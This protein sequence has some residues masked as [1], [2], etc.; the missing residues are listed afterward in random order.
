M[1]TDPTIVQPRLQESFSLVFGGRMS[2]TAGV[3]SCAAAWR[4]AALIGRLRA[5]QPFSLPDGFSAQRF[6]ADFGPFSAPAQ[7]PP[8]PAPGQQP[9]TLLTLTAKLYEWV[10]AL[11]SEL[12]RGRKLALHTLSPLLAEFRSSVLEIPGQYGGV[13]GCLALCVF[14]HI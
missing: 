7:P 13:R 14:P 10:V 12:R 8:P 1:V 5:P 6:V 2:W 4:G 9:S 11:Q 3:R